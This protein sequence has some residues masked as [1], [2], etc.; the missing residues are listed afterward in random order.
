MSTDAIVMLRDDHKKIRKLIHAYRAG[1][2]RVLGSTGDGVEETVARGEIVREL[3]HELTVHTFIEDEVMYPQVRRLVPETGSL[4]LEFH[5]EHHVANVL[6]AELE[7]MQQDHESFDAK[8]RVL[9][10]AVERHMDLEEKEWFPQVREALG[11]KALQAIGSRMAEVREHAPQR[12]HKPLLR[13][14]ADA[15]A[16]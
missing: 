15:M 9:M 16:S 13:K 2:E 3:L 12:P 14:L 11:R 1:G 4:V 6:A 7:G 10:D 5:E 8:A